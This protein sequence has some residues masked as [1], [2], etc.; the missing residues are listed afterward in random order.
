MVEVAPHLRIPAVEGRPQIR[1]P[2]IRIAVVAV[3]LPTASLSQNPVVRAVAINA[4][5][6]PIPLA[7]FPLPTA[8]LSLSRGFLQ[9]RKSALLGRSLFCLV[10]AW[11]LFL[12]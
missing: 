8:S 11:F 3:A 1:E 9:K 4:D 12:G 10:Q 6:F 5:P 2:R 7:S